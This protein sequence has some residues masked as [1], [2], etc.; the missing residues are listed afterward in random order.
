[1][2]ANNDPRA[3]KF[4]NEDAR[5]LADLF[6]STY[7]SSKVFQQRWTAQQMG[8]LIPFTSDLIVDGATVNGVDATGGDGRPLVTCANIEQVFNFASM[9]VSLFERGTADGSG[10]VNNA[11]LNNMLA[12]A[13]NGQSK[14]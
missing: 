3:V 10:N 8:T 1:M 14:F 4:S 11:W 9:V 12:V 6:V 5:V 2:A 7:N 13:V